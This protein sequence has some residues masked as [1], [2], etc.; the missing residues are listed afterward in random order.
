MSGETVLALCTGT[1]CRLPLVLRQSC[2]I[3]QLSHQFL[4]VLLFVAFVVFLFFSKRFLQ[5]ICH[6]P[7]CCLVLFC[8]FFDLQVK[9]AFQATNTWTYIILYTAKFLYWF[10]ICCHAGFLICSCSKTIHFV[11]RF[12]FTSWINVWSSVCFGLVLLC[13]FIYLIP[14][15]V[16]FYWT[17]NDTA[18]Q[19]L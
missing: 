15:L 2:Y 14:V 3:T 17:E 9:C 13:L 1:P 12:V 11:I 7:R 5:C 10:C 6:V 19:Q 4:V 18:P 16:G 8:A